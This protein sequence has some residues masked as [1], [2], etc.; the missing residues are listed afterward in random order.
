MIKRKKAELQNKRRTGEVVDLDQYSLKKIKMDEDTVKE[1][2]VEKLTEKALLLLIN[3]MN[4]GADEMYKD[5]YGDKWEEGKK[6]EQE[7]LAALRAEFK[8]QEA[9]REEHEKEV[10]ER[11]RIMLKRGGIF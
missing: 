1:E 5:M 11:E 4:E 2:D 7:K 10:L 9:A 8:R 3:Q 6:F